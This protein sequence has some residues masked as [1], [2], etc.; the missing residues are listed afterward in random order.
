MFRARYCLLS[1]SLRT[2]YDALIYPYLTYSII[3]WGNNYNSKVERRKLK[4]NGSQNHVYEITP[5]QLATFMYV[6]SNG[7]MPLGLE[8]TLQRTMLAV[9]I[10]PDLLR[11][12]LLFFK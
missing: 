12:Y 9:I 10:I 5:Y 3:I 1:N 6:Y 4:K 8:I 11:N 2:I 7:S